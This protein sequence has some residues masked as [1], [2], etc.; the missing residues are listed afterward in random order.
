MH[1]T[2]A[3]AH[4]AVARQG[5][6]LSALLL[7]V[8]V[9]DSD[10]VET[11]QTDGCRIAFSRKWL[12]S[13]SW[14]EAAYVLEHELLHIGLE[15][16]HRMRRF[17]PVYG[18]DA[19]NYVIDCEA[20]REL[21]KRPAHRFFSERLRSIGVVCPDWALDLSAEEILRRLPSGEA[22]GGQL[23]EH[24]PPPDDPEELERVRVHV[25]SAAMEALRT[26]E[27]AGT[28]PAQLRLAVE[29]L[30]LPV[31]IDWRAMLSQW[32]HNVARR[33]V[34]TWDHPRRR[35]WSLGL[36]LPSRRPLFS[37]MLV[38]D[39][40]G[41]MV[42]VQRQVLALLDELRVQTRATVL[43]MDCDCG[44]PHV[45]GELEP[46]DPLPTEW[47]GGGGTSFVPPFEWFHRHR[48][49]VDGI[50]YITD[51]YGGFPDPSLDPGVPV[52][53]VSTCKEDAKPPFGD[54]VFVK[55]ED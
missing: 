32:W 55:L 37:V 33:S 45:V 17:L 5:D 48:P 21:R 49:E 14:Q 23:D 43:L 25:L 34:P 7:R 52:L 18:K 9:T 6:F 28:V 19:V 8:A 11:A 3:K 27:H 30:T 12:D 50:V 44:E 29:R 20:E 42:H 41:S 51:M 1:P 40:S 4:R 53:W 13:L 54:V 15:H 46:D 35:S 38:R 36:Y 22:R 47:T 16:F 31:R 24:L 26:K 39:T 10:D 2:L